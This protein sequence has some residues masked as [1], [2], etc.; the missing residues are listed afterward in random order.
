MC[1]LVFSGCTKEENGPSIEQK[2]LGSWQLIEFFGTDGTVDSQWYPIDNGYVFTFK[3]NSVIGYSEATC[4]EIYEFLTN[5]RI[6]IIID[7]DGSGRFAQLEVSFEEG[8]L[9]LSSVPDDGCD[10]GCKEKFKRL[11]E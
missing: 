1:V 6:G 9:I 8:K 3:E 4:D 10:E 5:T 11:E 2:L 7:C